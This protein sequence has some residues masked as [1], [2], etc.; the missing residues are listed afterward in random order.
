MKEVILLGQTVNAYRDGDT[1][2][3]RLLTL[4][5]AIDG[6]ERIRFTSPHPCDMTESVIDA[7]AAQPKVQPYL[8][9][10]VQSGS[11]RM[12]AAMER[13]IASGNTSNWSSG[14]GA[15]FPAWRCPPISSSAFMARRRAISSRR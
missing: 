8:H 13:A 12:L 3:G 2:F 15:R 14:C 6:I 10:P 9:L 11:D 4:I 5:A 1:D 7:M